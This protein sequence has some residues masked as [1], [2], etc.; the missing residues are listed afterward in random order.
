MQPVGPEVDE[1]MVDGLAMVSQSYPVGSTTFIPS[2]LQDASAPYAQNDIYV[3][4]PSNVISAGYGYG[5]AFAP[6]YYGP[7]FAYPFPIF[8]NP[9]RHG[10][11]PVF[12][13]GPA[14]PGGPR[15]GGDAGIVIADHS[16]A[17]IPDSGGATF[18]WGQN[19]GPVST[20][21]M[22][23]GQSFPTQNGYVTS[24][25]SAGFS[26]FSGT[27]FNNTPNMMHGNGGFRGR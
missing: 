26:I 8:T 11:S 27:R 23:G 14:R 20:P 9:S 10:H 18:S 7:Q 5:G 22:G 24:G 21:F 19:P 4:A 12:H 3:Y 2:M 1:P 15:G 16:S 17:G 25:A 6:D 13:H